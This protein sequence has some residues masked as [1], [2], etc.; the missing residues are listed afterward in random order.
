M[1]SIHL[2]SKQT[3]IQMRHGLKNPVKIAIKKFEQHASIN[4]VNN[5]ITNN[6]RFHFLPTEQESSLKEIIN[7]DNKKMGLLKT[8]LLAVSKM[9]H[10]CS[11]ILANIQNEKILLSK[12]SL[13]NYKLADVSPIFKKEDRTFVE[14]YRPVSVLPTV[15]KIFEQTMQK[16]TSDCT[17]KFL[18]GYFPV[19][20]EKDLVHNLP[21]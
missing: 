19:D 9:Y 8:L 11:P 13:E 3:N 12:N 18:S 1:L 14:N 10:I 5:N 6:E 7:L 21:Y 17:G 15:Y 2:K 4:L 20:I 16:Q